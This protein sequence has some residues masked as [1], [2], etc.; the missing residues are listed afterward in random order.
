MASSRRT[1]ANIG[2]LFGPWLVDS[3]QGRP[4]ASDEIRLTQWVLEVLADVMTVTPPPPVDPPPGGGE[5]AEPIQPLAGIDICGTE[6]PLAWWELDNGTTMRRYA[7]TAINIGDPKEP[8]VASLG[9]IRR[10]LSPELTDLRSATVAPVLI[11]TDRAL[12]AQEAADTLIGTRASAYVSTVAA[13]RTGVAPRRVFDGLVTDTEP[14]DALQFRLQVSDVLSGFV[15]P[16]DDRTYPQRVFD[17]PD[18]PNMGNPVDHPTSP[19]NPEMLRKPVPVI[20]GLLSDEQ[21]GSPE[22][23]CPWVYTGKRLVPFYNTQ[24]DEYVLCG[25]AVKQIQSL[26]VPS[27]GGLSTGTVYPTRIR[28]TASS[29][30]AEYIFPGTPQWTQAFGAAPY[31]E[32]NGRR[33]TVLY[34]FGPRSDLNRL[35][36]V[37]LL[38]NVAGIESVGNGSGTLIDG[39]YRVIVHLLTNWILQS[40]QAGSW[41]PLPMV[42][43]GASAY[44]RIDVP[45]FEA[46]QT[47]SAAFMTPTGFKAAFILGYPPASRAWSFNEVL[48]E[49][50]RCGRYRHGINKDG[51]ISCVLRTVVGATARALTATADVLVDS[52]TAKRQRDA[53]RNV[54]D[55]RF[56][57]RYAPAITQVLPTGGQLPVDAEKPQTEWI[58]EQLNQWPDAASIAKYGRRPIDLSFEFLRDTTANWVALMTVLELLAPRARV[59]LAEGPCGTKTDL[60]QYV[61]LSHPE[62]IGAS[63]YVNRLLQCDTHA[64][65]LDQMTVTAEYV[66]VDDLPM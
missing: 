45:S 30:Y 49:A 46:A 34:A 22:G 6:A 43:S 13:L 9:T 51:Q 44:A 28:I 26:F 56:A 29:G 5:V 15:D 62:G 64:F 60:G 1:M 36:T 25:H 38:A 66:D 42:G 33:Y 10:A 12:R 57:R 27:G 8:R 7:G 21:I 54:A 17:L 53:I 58:I 18:F 63:G 14:L 4:P 11:D 37:P 55:M 23:V 2:T 47:N 31:R 24:F 32:F 40:Y 39:Y 48:A 50:A 3:S 61:R 65:D 16:V 19:G 59:R 52:L 35:G 41:L 20:Y